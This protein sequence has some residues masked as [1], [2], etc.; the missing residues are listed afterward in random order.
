MKDIGGYYGPLKSKW[1]FFSYLAKF[2]GQ[3]FKILV[4]SPSFGCFQYNAVNLGLNEGY[5]GG[6]YAPLPP[7]KMEIS[8]H[9]QRV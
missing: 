4:L 8:R 5:T 6:Y 3:K 2:W 9:D 7:K 1:I